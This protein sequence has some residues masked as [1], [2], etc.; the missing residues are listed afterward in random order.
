MVN[1]VMRAS[2]TQQTSSSWYLG[3]NLA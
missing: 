2:Y 3:K 1:F